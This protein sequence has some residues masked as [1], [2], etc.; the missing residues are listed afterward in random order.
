MEDNDITMNMTQIYCSIC[1][2][3]KKIEI[4][5][6]WKE[7]TIFVSF[8]CGHERKKQREDENIDY[9]INCNKYI[10]ENK[11]CIESNHQFI[12]KDELHFYCTI[13]MKKFNA[14]C[15]KCK[16]NLCDECLCEHEDIKYNFEYY[17]SYSQIEELESVYNEV[18]NYINI[19][20]SL[21][22]NKIISEDFENY[23]QIHLY[24]YKNEFFHISIIY[25]INLFYNF[26]KHLLN[27]KLVFTGSFSIL[28]INNINDRTIFYDSL[29]KEEFGELINDED[30][31][32]K[33]ILKLFLLSKRFKIDQDLFDKFSI[34]INSLISVNNSDINKLNIKIGKFKEIM[35]NLYDDIKSKKSEIEHIKLKIDNEILS[36]KFSKIAVP[37]NLKRKLISITQR[38]I[39]KKYRNNLHKIK[40]NIIILNNIKKRYESLKKQNKETYMTLNLEKKVNEIDNINPDVKYDFVDNVYFEAN[41]ALKSLLNAFIYFTQKLHYKKSNET[42]YSNKN[43]IQSFPLNQIFANNINLSG[44]NAIKN[45]MTSSDIDNN[46]SISIDRKNNNEKMKEYKTYLMELKDN[47]KN[48]NKDI[49]IKKKINLKDVLEAL[50]Q[51]N[52]SNIIDIVDNN[53]DSEIDEYISECCDEIEKYEYKEEIYQYPF[54]NIYN[55]IKNNNFL[56]KSE[57]ILSI[58]ANDRKYKNSIKAIK[59][60]SENDNPEIRQNHR[61]LIQNLMQSGGFDKR[62][63]NS[64]IEIIDNYLNYSKEIIGI[65]EEIKKYKLCVKE[66]SELEFEIKQLNNIR[67]YLKIFNKELTE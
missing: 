11:N 35:R 32:F 48:S 30:L 24:L 64:I 36:I 16:K 5:S 26:F 33:N 10:K 13:H 53:N 9:C 28:E 7:K 39:I 55:Q 25:N 43:Q 17:L 67:D 60:N 57:K 61:I 1:N 2:D 54:S 27:S 45:N 52:F 47:F 63:A 65:D 4:N 41:F 12:K 51:N 62:N 56:I 29:F 23:Y 31:D 19:I 22:C 37:S 59:E 20:Y 58:L 46:H 38:E 6:N 8:E 18:Q 44:H 15:D 66:K 49:F 34:K 50:F 14:Y 3:I 21:E 40:P 42:H